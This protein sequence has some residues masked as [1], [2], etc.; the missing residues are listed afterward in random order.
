MSEATTASA[1]PAETRHRSSGG[2][3]GA[4]CLLRDRAFLLEAFLAF[5]LLGLVADIAV[6]HSTNDFAE[7]SEW[8]P[9]AY[10]VAGG[11]LLGANLLRSAPIR[12]ARGF[13]EDTGW[14]LGIVVGA[15]GVL[16]GVSGLVLHLESNFFQ[17]MTLRSLVYSAPFVAPLSFAGLGFLVILNRMADHGSEEWARWVLFFATAGFLGNFGISLS[18]HA[19]NGFFYAPEWVAVVMGAV[20]F[21]YLVTLFVRTP[22]PGYIRLGWWVLGAEILTGMLG[23]GFHLH[24]L[25]DQA[26]GTFVQRVMHGAP[27]F[28][29]LLFADLALLGALGLRELQVV[30]GLDAGAGGGD[31]RG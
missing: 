9:V 24:P 16:V 29:P 20:G 28:P 2:R 18:D 3:R 26:S 27:P 11:L 7:W 17:V 14:W 23:L 30:L 12:E 4:G 15:A 6:A 10:A 19:Q 22:D 13:H 1:A 5:N 25:L 31:A 21:A 8:I